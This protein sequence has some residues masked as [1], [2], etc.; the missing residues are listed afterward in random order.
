MRHRGGTTR[1]G[2]GHEDPVFQVEC[3]DGEI[4]HEAPFAT[5]R[6][7]MNFAEW[8]HAC[9]TSHLITPMDRGA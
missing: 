8:G 4:R 9:T 6:D 5:R 3:E 2:A 1:E 7:A